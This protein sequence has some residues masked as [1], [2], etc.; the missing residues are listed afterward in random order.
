M[1]WKQG[2]FL[3]EFYSVP[4]VAPLRVNHTPQQLVLTSGRWLEE[5]RSASRD[6][7]Q[8]DSRW[9][10][11]ATDLPSQAS[12]SQDGVSI[13]DLLDRQRTVFGLSEAAG[14]T[15]LRVVEQLRRLEREQLVECVPQQ[16][17]GEAPETLVQSVGAANRP[18]AARPAS[19]STICPTRRLESTA[20]TPAPAT[21]R[22][23]ISV[24]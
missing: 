4:Q 19:S 21:T 17:C 13:L 20:G 23:R 24:L 2:D 14:M 3:A 22:S 11:T 1:S 16:T 12:S 18:D 7:Y 10:R 9:Q 6:G 8:M 5:T 15:S